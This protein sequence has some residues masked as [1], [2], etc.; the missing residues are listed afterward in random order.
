MAATVIAARQAGRAWVNKTTNYTLTA[1]DYG[2][3]VDSTSLAIT[4]TLPTAVGIVDK[5]YHIK[6]WKGTSAIYNITIVTTSSQTIDGATT[7]VISTPY[8][9]IQVVSDGANWG[10][11]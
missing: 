10:I 3:R 2:V 1:V 6:D 8:D 9:A 11:I 4:I 7:F 5:A